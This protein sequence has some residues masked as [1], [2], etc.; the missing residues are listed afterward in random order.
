MDNLDLERNLQNYNEMGTSITDLKADNLPKY[1]DREPFKDIPQK[2]QT[3]ETGMNQLKKECTNCDEKDFNVNNFIKD[4]EKNLD[5]FDNVDFQSGPLPS[6]LNENFQNQ[7]KEKILE[8]LVDDKPT[9]VD[10]K[11]KSMNAIKKARKDKQSNN[12]KMYKILTK[13]RE[14]V[15]IILL[16]VLLN[17]P[18]LIQIVD[19]IPYMNYFDSPYPSLIFRGGILAIIIY[20]L[21]KYS[22]F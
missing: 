3:G 4:L 5:N 10:T 22:T 18:E 7:K 12:N 8:K 16:F 2:G 14:L 19:Q 15:I 20:Y 9:M 21:K 6:N 17:N 11:M 1:A 13:I